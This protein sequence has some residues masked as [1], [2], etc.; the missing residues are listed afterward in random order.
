[1]YQEIHAFPYTPWF[2]TVEPFYEGCKRELSNSQIT[3]PSVQK[4][5]KG[6]FKTN[7]MQI[8]SFKTA[9]D[10]FASKNIGKIGATSTTSAH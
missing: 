6:R 7:Q 3:R 8:T 5:T 9:I 4:R 1:M 10:V 2:K